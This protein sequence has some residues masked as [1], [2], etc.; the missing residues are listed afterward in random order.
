VANNK[1]PNVKQPGEKAEGKFRYNPGN[2][3][4][5]TVKTGDDGTEEKPKG[6]E[7]RNPNEL[8]RIAS[9]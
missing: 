4:V 1:N 2:M 7:A 9:K 6:N 5:K 8:P 3:S